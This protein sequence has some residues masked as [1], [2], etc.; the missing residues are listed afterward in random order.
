[1]R[2]AAVG[3]GCRGVETIDLEMSD[4]LKVESETLLRVLLPF[5]PFLLWTPLF[6]AG[7]LVCSRLCFE[8]GDVL[9]FEA[10]STLKI[11][12]K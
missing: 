3:L 2:F 9:H 6:V 11:G 5:L 4:T 10:I 1:M 7:S 12:C 8:A